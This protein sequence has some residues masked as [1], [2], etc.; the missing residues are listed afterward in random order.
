[1]SGA[2]RYL[3]ITITFGALLCGMLAI[4]LAS[5]GHLTGAGMLILAAYLLDAVDG[6][7]ARRLK[8][9]SEFGIQLDSLVDMV[10][11]GAGSANLVINYLRGSAFGG[12]PAWT[13]GFVFVMAGA[14]RLARYNLGATASKKRDTL[15]LTIST[16]GA[17]ITLSVLTDMAY[18]RPLFP[19]WAWL[20]LLLSAALLMASRIQFPE[21][22]VIIANRWFSLAALS[23]CGAVAIWLRP[24]TVWWAMTTGYISYGVL[25]AATR[26]L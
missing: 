13:A 19:S 16:A 18:T 25:R 5:E 4:P 2:R 12:W 3:P 8:A 21:L 10:G 23:V 9:T 20:V 24:Q 15:G 14:Y 17:F 1:V 26:A 6:E 11:F 7:L 22:G